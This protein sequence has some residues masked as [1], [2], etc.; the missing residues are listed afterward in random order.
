MP[1]GTSTGPACRHVVSLLACC[2]GCGPHQLA[3]VCL[4]SRRKIPLAQAAPSR[5]PTERGD[6]PRACHRVERRVRGVSAHWST[7]RERARWQNTTQGGPLRQYKPKWPHTFPISCREATTAAFTPLSLTVGSG[8]NSSVAH[9]PTLIPL[10]RLL[11]R[12]A[13]TIGRGNE[14][15]MT[16]KRRCPSSGWGR[17]ASTYLFEQESC[18][19]VSPFGISHRSNLWSHHSRTDCCI[20]AGDA[21]CF[22]D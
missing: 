13:I 6:E 1:Q 11:T 17:C 2:S 20:P 21:L 10:S 14:T 3:L 22:S 15:Q 4:R 5:S 12:S 9:L 18:Y 19:A 7:S 16:C 8:S